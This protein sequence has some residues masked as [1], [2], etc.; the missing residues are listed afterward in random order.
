MVFPT[1]VRSCRNAIP[2]AIG[3]KHGPKKSQLAAATVSEVETQFDTGTDMHNH[4]M[5]W[6]G[7]PPATL[8]VNCGASDSNDTPVELLDYSNQ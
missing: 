4:A 5:R 8:A 3:E 7:S 6:P 1:C 2:G